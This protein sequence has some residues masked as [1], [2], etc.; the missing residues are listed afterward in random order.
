MRQRPSASSDPRRR[1]RSAHPRTDEAREQQT[2]TSEVLQ[3]ISSFAGELDPVFEAILANATRICEAK[4]GNLLSMKRDAFAS[5]YTATAC[6]RR[7]IAERGSN[8]AP[9]LWA[10]G[11]STK[12]VAITPTTPDSPGD[13][14]SWQRRLAVS[15]LLARTDAQG[16]R[17]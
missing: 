2:A 11:R 1:S 13:P 7:T 8:P 16:E 5:R 17:N 4:F 15:D 12:Q 9:R 3:V 10:F 14:V 6:V